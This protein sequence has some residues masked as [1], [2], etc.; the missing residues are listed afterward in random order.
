MMVACKRKEAGKEVASGVRVEITPFKINKI[1]LRD[2][3]SIRNVFYNQSDS[4]RTSVYGYLYDYDKET[5]YLNSYQFNEFSRS[6]WDLIKNPGDH[7]YYDPNGK[8]LTQ[9]EAM[10]RIVRCD[11]IQQVEFDSEGNEIIRSRYM[12]DSASA[13][14]NINMIKFYETWYF[15]PANNMIERDILGY[16]LHEFVADKMAFREL[17]TVFVNDA[18]LKKA[19]QYYF[20]KH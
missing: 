4:G 13:V 2:T 1:I 7:V 17:F 18:A 9:K 14:F 16:S 6:V 20:S 5:R 19:K 12:C 15:N 3:T 11:M 10:D 8:A